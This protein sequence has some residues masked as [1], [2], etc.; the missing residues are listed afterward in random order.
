MAFGGGNRF[1]VGGGPFLGQ[2]FRSGDRFAFRAFARFAFGGGSRL[3]FGG[4]RNRLEFRL[5]DVERRVEIDV[6][7]VLVAGARGL[8][9]LPFV[10]AR[11]PELIGVRE[12]QIV[13]LRG[14]RLVMARA[15]RDLFGV[16]RRGDR[17][18]LDVRGLDAG[19]RLRGALRRRRVL[20]CRL[21]PAGHIR[22]HGD[23]G[24]NGQAQRR[25]DR[26]RRRRREQFLGD[27]VVFHDAPPADFHPHIV[28]TARGDDGEVL[29]GEFR[30][31]GQVILNR[32]ELVERVLDLRRQ[33]LADDAAHRI[34]RQA[35]ARE[36]H[37]AV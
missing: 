3:A 15:R 7:L 20:R 32:P 1:A 35:T 22:E 25:F 11:R 30:T 10:I 8:A 24:H 27:A 9:H 19:G 21:R 17:R 23:R 5:L 2:A 18:S 36:L 12:Q 34:E 29:A 26:R 37:L 4:V 14:R 13:V 28:P 6:D 16:R 31:C 33:Q